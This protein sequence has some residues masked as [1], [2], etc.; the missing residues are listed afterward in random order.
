LNNDT[1][2]GRDAIGALVQ[3]MSAHPQV[4]MAGPRLIGSDGRP[5]ISYRARPTLAALL[6]RIPLIRITG[7]FRKAYYRYR[8]W[9]FNPDELRPVEAL[10][11]AAVCLPRDLFAQIGG[12]DEGYPFGLEDFDLSA[13]VAKTH[14]VVYFPGAEIVHLGGVSSRS[15]SGF[16]YT[17]LECSYVRYLRKQGQSGVAIAFYKLLLVANLP[18]ALLLQAFNA[19]RKRLRPGHSPTGQPYS[20]F[21]AIW[22]FAT[23]GLGK[24]WRA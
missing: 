15:N 4:G 10:L 19:V 20:Q 1:I 12:W 5:Q 8:R 14:Q 3:F 16:A 22:F 9:T 21:G 2:V 23:R 13:R 24:F 11:G 7:L 6:H 18:L 17:G